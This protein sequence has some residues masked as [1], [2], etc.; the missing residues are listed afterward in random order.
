MSRLVASGADRWLTLHVHSDLQ[1]ACDALDTDGY[2][3]AATDVGGSVAPRSPSEITIDM[4]LA[5]AF[6]NERD[7]ISAELRERATMLMHIPMSGF[8]ESLNI[9]VA[10]AIA[11]SRI[12]E[13]LEHTNP[14][15]WRLSEES[16]S[17]LLDGWVLQ[18][19]PHA[20]SVLKEIAK[21]QL[22]R[23]SDKGGSD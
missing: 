23:L 12:R 15:Q 14:C 2:R 5:L 20:R 8:V 11:V 3:L 16:R 13:R 19:V 22:S 17:R 1:S 6:G 18:D 21:R 4:P 10:V 7:G 9:S